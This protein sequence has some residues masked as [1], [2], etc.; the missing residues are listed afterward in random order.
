MVAAE[1][2]KVENTTAQ[3]DAS[4]GAK[5][6][7]GEAFGSKQ[8]TTQGP[9]FREPSKILHDLRDHSA[10]LVR[11][12]QIFIRGIIERTKLAVTKLIVLAVLGVV[13]LLACA[14]LVIVATSMLLG[15]IAGAL[16]E[17]THHRWI[18]DLITSVIVLG[19]I[20]ALGFLFYHRVVVLTR[21]QVRTRIGEHK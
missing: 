17:L 18:G 12:F 2:P 6:A 13:A 9:P 4:Q 3:N 16:G 8:A 19:G 10:D 11:E 15:G 14:S 20:G 1:E 21:K 5:V 7:P